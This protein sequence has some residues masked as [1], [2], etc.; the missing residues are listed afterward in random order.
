MLANRMAWFLV[1]LILVTT[2]A[3]CAAPPTPTPTPAPTASPIPPTPVPTSTRVPPS[4]TPVPPTATTVPPTATRVSPTAT[5]VPPT[6]TTA[7]E[8]TASVTWLGHATFVLKMSTGLT[9]L[10]D[11]MNDSVGYPL[12][13]VAG[14]DLV[15]TTHEHSDHNNVALAT[16]SPQIVRG[17]AGN[18]W[19]KIDQT[20]KGVRVRTVQTYH[21]DTQG[22]QRG[23]NA[24][25]IFEMDGLKLAHLGDLGHTLNADQVKAIGAIDVVMIPVGGFF[26]IDGIGAAEV[27]T[28]LN[29]KIVIPMHYKTPA[30]G[31]S[32]AGRLT[33]LG[34]FTSAL[35][36]TT[37]VTQ[38]A[39]TITISSSK[40]PATRAVMVLNYK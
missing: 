8:T 36:N 27:V 9:V 10:A 23:K 2:L 1:V 15:T 24:I 31:A 16:G 4:A 6:P 40:L 39:Q 22:S 26:T 19:A 20:I 33:D 21:D 37:Q 13:P 32:L 25:F 38:T 3:A 28:Q 12:T 34:A 5:S 17:L 18:D 7:K 14:V 35:G 29:P 11:P 30:L